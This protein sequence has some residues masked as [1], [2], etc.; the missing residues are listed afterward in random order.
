M[1]S[2]LI[3]LSPVRV[4]FVFCSHPIHGWKKHRQ[5]LLIMASRKRFSC[6]WGSIGVAGVLLAMPWL[7]LKKNGCFTGRG[8]T[9]KSYPVIRGFLMNHK[10]DPVFKQPGWLM[11]SIKVKEFFFCS[12]TTSSSPS[13]KKS[14]HYRFPTRWISSRVDGSNG[15]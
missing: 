15:L 14:P 4:S 6:I 5:Q 3:S 7:S 9:W 2:Y 1:R 11:E 12:S 8:R 13:G 10:K